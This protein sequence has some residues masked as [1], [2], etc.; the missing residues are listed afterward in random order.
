MNLSRLR[1]IVHFINPHKSVITQV[2]V[3]FSHIY[4]SLLYTHHKSLGFTYYKQI[5][6]FV[7]LATKSFDFHTGSLMVFEDY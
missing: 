2:Y 1:C 5:F 7:L 6:F 3:Y 4:L